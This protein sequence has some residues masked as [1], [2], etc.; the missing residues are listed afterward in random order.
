TQSFIREPS[1]IIEARQ[2]PRSIAPAQQVPSVMPTLY[3]ISPLLDFG[4][5]LSSQNKA[6]SV[7][8]D[9]SRFLQP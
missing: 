1:S 7:S 2:F 3:V 6:L 8:L 9:C 4:G 5:Y